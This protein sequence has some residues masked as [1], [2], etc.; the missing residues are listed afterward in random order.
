MT[1]ITVRARAFLRFVDLER[2][3]VE[4]LAVQR[5][6]GARGVLARHLD[7]AEATW[8]A[9]VAIVDQRN[10]LHR[11]VNREKR[12]YGVFGRRERKVSD[13]KFG[14]FESRVEGIR[15]PRRASGAH[16]EFKSLLS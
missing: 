14:H 4:V 8:A 5:L 13:I 1:R 9:R 10:L 6:H 11:A 3:A 16:R 7:E 15:F 12:S 2:A